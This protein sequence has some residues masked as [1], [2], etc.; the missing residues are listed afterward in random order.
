MWMIYAML[1][2]ITKATQLTDSLLVTS[3]LSSTVH[4]RF[5]VAEYASQRH[6]HVFLVLQSLLDAGHSACTIKLGQIHSD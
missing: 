6:Y 4:L 2:I 1:S 5:P 3:I